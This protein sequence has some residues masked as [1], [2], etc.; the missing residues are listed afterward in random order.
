MVVMRTIRKCDLL[1]RDAVAIQFGRA[2]ERCPKEVA[3]EGDSAPELRDLRE[4]KL[5]VE[6]E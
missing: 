3:L 1:N 6:V 4:G 5:L 2:G